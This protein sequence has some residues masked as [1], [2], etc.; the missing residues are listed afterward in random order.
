MPTRAARPAAGRWHNAAMPKASRVPGM[1]EYREVVQPAEILQR[2]AYEHWLGPLVMRHLSP[3]VSRACV[4][5]GMSPNQ[6]TGMM[7]VTGLA[8]ATSLLL[9]GLWGPALCLFFGQLQLL[10]DCAD[11]EVARWLKLTSPKGIFLDAVAHYTVEGLVPFFLGLRAALSADQPQW[12]WAALGG[13]LSLLLVY[14]KAL[15]ELVHV[16]RAK[17]GL[18]LVK[19]DP[20]AGTPQRSGVRRLRRLANLLPIHRLFHWVE[21]TFWCFLA[22]VAGL[23]VGQHEAAVGLLAVLTPLAALTLIGHFVAI[24]SSSKLRAG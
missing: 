16:A 6:V 7:V 10:L 2:S 5:L 15:N 4:A 14:N 17:Y 21:L 12:Q 1:R 19:D 8:A 23:L 11:G 20:A 13:L 24:M 9:P 3:Y 22:G 18:A